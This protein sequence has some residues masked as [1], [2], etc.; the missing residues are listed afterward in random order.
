MNCAVLIPKSDRLTSNFSLQNRYIAK[1][2]GHESI[3]NHR[4]G[5]IVLIYRQILITRHKKYVAINNRNWDFVISVEEGQV[6][7]STTFNEMADKLIRVG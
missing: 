7:D 3:E 4:L 2:T 5:Y 6:I 1:Q